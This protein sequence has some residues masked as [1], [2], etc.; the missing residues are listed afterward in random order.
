MHCGLSIGLEGLGLVDGER[1]FGPLATLLGVSERAQLGK[2]A[3]GLPPSV[4][5]IGGGGSWSSGTDQAAE[6]AT[7]IPG[8]T[9]VITQADRTS[10]RTNDELRPPA[11]MAVIRWDERDVGRW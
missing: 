2:A 3:L 10:R 6:N 8:D 5:D 11:V 1:A 4:L 7:L 9:A